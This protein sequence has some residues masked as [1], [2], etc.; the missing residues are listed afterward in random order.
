MTMNICLAMFRGFV[1]SVRG[2]VVL[3]YM[4]KEMNERANLK[5]T[6]QRSP[7][8]NPHNKSSQKSTNQHEESKVMTRIIQCCA[9]NGGVFWT[10]IFIF[11]YILLP[12]LKLFLSFLLGHDK[13]TAHDIWYWMEPFLSLTFRMFW[14]VPLFL[15][16]KIVNS[17]WF[18]DIADSAF[19]Y[20]RGRPQFISS[21]SKL[22]ADTLFSLL[23]Q[24]LFLLQAMLM[25]WFPITPI[26]DF[27]CLIH[28]C[29]L[30]SLYVF[31][32]KWFNMGWELHSR[33]T[34]IET[35]WPYFIGFGLPLAVLTQ[36]PG[37]YLISGCVF[38]IL[39]PLFILSGN[40]ASPVTDACDISIPLFKPVIAISNTLF[41]QTIKP[42]PQIISTRQKEIQNQHSKQYN[43]SFD[44]RYR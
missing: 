30:Y 21:I 19:R 37:S 36:L 39:F 4:D 8:N 32:Y 3:F 25:Q 23:V 15:L 24:V 28:M 12:G 43:R 22:I 31:E 10:S 9:L 11:E 7:A 26:G 6:T 17:L 14:V 35:N 5:L 27:L 18:Q 2:M 29:L 41:N 38:S 1:D 13:G 34:F 16:S 20:S 42:K 44:P 33:L 40:E